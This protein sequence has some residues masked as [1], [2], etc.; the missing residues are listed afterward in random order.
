M[1]PVYEAALPTIQRHDRAGEIGWRGEA[2]K[3][4]YTSRLRHQTVAKAKRGPDR[5][6][7]HPIDT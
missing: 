4:R 7:R 2:C 3:Y 5:A 1:P 6:N